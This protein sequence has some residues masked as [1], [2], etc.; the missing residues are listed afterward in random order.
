MLNS[1]NENNSAL[2][3]QAKQKLKSVFGYSK[4]RSHQQDIID[5]V[6]AGKSCVVIMP[7]GSGKSLCYQ[8]PAMVFEGLTV[9][10]SPLISLM[11]NQ[12]TQLRELGV[13]A[14][15]LNSSLTGQQYADVHHKVKTGQTK[16]LYLAPETLALPIT[17]QLLNS[18]KVEFLA[19]D[20]A[21]CISEW[22]HDFR[23]EYRQIA[24]IRKELG[25]IPTIALTATATPRVQD[26][27][28]QNLGLED[29]QLFKT[30]F[31]RDN[32]FLEV[33]PKS[34]PFKQTTDF[35][36]KFPDESAIIYCFSRKGVDELSKKLNGAGFT[37]LPYHAGLDNEIRKEN[38]EKFIKDDVQIIVATVAFG[39][40]I[41]KPNIRS[42]IHYDL[43]KDIESYYQQIGRAGRD[44]SDAYCLLLFGYQDVAKLKF[45]FQNKEGQELKNA[46][47]HLE[48]MLNYTETEE[49]RR[50]VL[51]NYFG[52]DYQ[53]ENCHTCDNCVKEKQEKD[54]LTV[55]VQKFLS[56]IYRTDQYFGSNHIIKILRGSSDKKI[57]ERRHDQ[58]STYG[59]GK[60]LSVKQW[61]HLYRQV[62]RAKLITVDPQYGS[63]K[64][65]EAG[66]EILKNR[67]KFQGNLIEEKSKIKK[68]KLNLEYDTELFELLRAK[69][70]EL[71][72]AKGIPPYTVFHDKTLAEIC[73]VYPKTPDELLDISGIGNAKLEK[74]GKALFDI[75]LPYC[76]KKGI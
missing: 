16:I 42:V 68:R 2:S 65:T 40:G 14:E 62:Q 50:I 71:A 7:T 57:L 58:I 6:L 3:N 70:K 32:L 15:V 11:K 28:A 12:V 19:V 47:R 56:C 10:I 63:M 27:I 24:Q 20:E 51:L 23:P 45:L 31:N 17:R 46:Y 67:G 18:V 34:D 61:L 69:R 4:F 9:V 41:D 55:H 48:S 21:H 5:T 13:E 75:I 33:M 29:H 8:I 1:G 72:D 64:L 53:I 74:Y 22:G 37:S 25:N 59:I 30:S 49:C 43:P 39:M 52:E 73:T 35:L 76:L 44:G 66:I 60:D 36:N 54:D 38:Q 26:D